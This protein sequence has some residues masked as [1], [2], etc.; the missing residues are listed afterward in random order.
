[1]S[2]IAQ[3]DHEFVDVLPDELQEGVL[4]I[5]LEFTT[6]AHLCCCGCGNQVITP[7]KPTRWRLTFD[8]E[9]ISLYPSIGNWDFPCESHYFIERSKVRWAP[10][11]S[12]AEVEAIRERAREGWVS[13]DAGDTEPLAPA[14]DEPA[15][16]KAKPTGTRKRGR[17]GRVKR[18]FSR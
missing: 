10:Q 11:M 9:S 1:M 18:F 16:A 6:V 2:R 5:S 14:S 17:W 7:L 3:L 4:Y 13:P 8:G 15:D 12:R